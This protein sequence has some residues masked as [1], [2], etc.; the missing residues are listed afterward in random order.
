MA[1]EV[2]QDEPNMVPKG[3]WRPRAGEGTD[4]G[5]CET[6]EGYANRWRGMRVQRWVGP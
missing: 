5:V 1:Q 2:A 6:M 3:L 4:G